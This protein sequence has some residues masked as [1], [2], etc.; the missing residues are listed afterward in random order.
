MFRLFCQK[1]RIEQ[2]RTDGFEAFRLYVNPLISIFPNQMCG[3][4]VAVLLALWV[5]FGW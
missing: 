3:S 5:A 1:H 2:V 4:Y